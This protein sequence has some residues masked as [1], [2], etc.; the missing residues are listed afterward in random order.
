MYVTDIKQRNRIHNNVKMLN[1][2]GAAVVFLSLFVEMQTRLSNRTQSICIWGTR[3]YTVGLDFDG[4]CVSQ[5]IRQQYFAI[6]K[7]RKRIEIK[8]RIDSILRRDETIPFSKK[9][10]SPLVVVMVAEQLKVN[11]LYAFPQSFNC[12]RPSPCHRHF[13]NS[14]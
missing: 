2:H 7:E 3:A 10:G 11:L 1:V 6:A 14:I 4:N 5:F 13:W 9:G 12:L 8:Q